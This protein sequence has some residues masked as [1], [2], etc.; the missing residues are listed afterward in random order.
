M[1][2]AKS[3]TMEQL[4]QTAMIGYQSFIIWE[5]SLERRKKSAM[6]VIAT[7][8]SV[9][10]RGGRVSISHLFGAASLQV[11]YWQITHLCDQTRGTLGNGW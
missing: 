8:K 3:A 9:R 2:T 7:L 1:L 4:M 6:T 11:G 10:L 5:I